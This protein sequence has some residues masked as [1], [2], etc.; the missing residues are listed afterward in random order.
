MAA[1]L[2]KLSEICDPQFAADLKKSQTLFF[3]ARLE[4]VIQTLSEE[5]F[6]D[7]L[8]HENLNEENIGRVAKMCHIF[9]DMKT[10]LTNRENFAA[11]IQTVLS[12][13]TNMGYR[14][15]I[16]PL[17]VDVFP[18]SNSAVEDLLTDL[19][20]EF[21]KNQKSYQLKAILDTMDLYEQKRKKINI[22]A[23]SIVTSAY[24]TAL[25]KWI[26][27]IV[28]KVCDKQIQKQCGSLLSQIEFNEDNSRKRKRVDNESPTQKMFAASASSYGKLQ[29]ISPFETKGFGTLQ[30]ERDN[31][32]DTFTED[33][34]PL[35]PSASTALSPSDSS[36]CNSQ[37]DEPINGDCLHR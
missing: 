22:S 20:A 24:G 16:A 27:S 21:Q 29:P 32:G 8:S 4:N 25:P 15:Y 9:L 18:E 36:E 5:T 12:L 2:K 1:T 35:S 19:N 37:K 34:C 23:F 3:K 13:L 33:T 10:Q 26:L 17:L 31:D 11:C 6:F 14:N 7:S 28:Q 30:V